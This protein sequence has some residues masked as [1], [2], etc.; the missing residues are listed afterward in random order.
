[1]GAVYRARDARLSR[2]F[3]QRVQLNQDLM[4]IENFVVRQRAMTAL[5]ADKSSVR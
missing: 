1:M 4:L 3:A 5:E 2:N